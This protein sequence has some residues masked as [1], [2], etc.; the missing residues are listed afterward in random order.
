M[1]IKMYE[2]DEYAIL[3]IAG[4]KI[5]QR[6][7]WSPKWYVKYFKIFELIDN[8]VPK[9]KNK[10]M[11]CS[12]PDYSDN[13]KQ[14][15]EYLKK[16]YGDKYEFVWAYRNNKYYNFF[17]NKVDC[18]F[19]YHYSLACI[20]HAMTSKY[21]IVTH[22]N[23]FFNFKKH[24][25]LSLWHGMPV[26][27][28]GFAE[29]NMIPERLKNIKEFGEN[30]YF[31]V[32]SDIFK[33]C[34]AYCFGAHPN[35]IFITGQPRT[36]SIFSPGINAVNYINNIKKDFDKIILYTPTYK[37]RMVGKVREIEKPFN[38]IFY[39]DDYNEEDFYKYLKENNILFLMK[40]HP[41]DEFF[42]YNYI[43]ENNVPE[44][45]K[46]IF[47]QDLKD[48]NIYFY[49]IFSMCELMVG[50]YSSI[51]TDWLIQ[52][53]P[54]IF[55]SSVVDEYKESRGF[56]FEDNYKIMLPGPIVY[57]Y[58]ELIEEIDLN[59]K[60]PE[61]FKEKYGERFNLLFK[62]FDG[63]ASDRIYNIMQTL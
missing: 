20:F 16:Y 39:L 50:D 46:I 13:A 34:M 32:T 31:F 51:A 62:Y 14:F 19:V 41:Q 8:I 23:I 58:K 60:N 37:E 7:K 24:I 38:N 22:D 10:I 18:K 2:T 59:L 6:K 35:K 53:K 17:K 40:P 5:K 61:A 27:T 44:N 28:I 30:S 49:E 15:Y 54:A 9:K 12:W 57:N 25:T 55:I 11:F 26:K 63:N 47:D 52:K 33:V 48:N 43:K 42:Y 1:F 21:Y 36:D 29:K 45:I 4:I 3:S 56:C